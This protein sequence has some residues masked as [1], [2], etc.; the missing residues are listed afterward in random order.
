MGYEYTAAGRPP[1]RV[2]ATRTGTGSTWVY[3]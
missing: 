2:D 3:G 1:V